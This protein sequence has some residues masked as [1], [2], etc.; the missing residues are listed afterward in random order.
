[1]CTI[2]QYVFLRKTI[3]RQTRRIR[4]SLGITNSEKD[5][6]GDRER[7]ENTS[8]R[9][10]V[11]VLLGLFLPSFLLLFFFLGSFEHRPG[12]HMESP[13]LAHALSPS[14]DPSVSSSEIFSPKRFTSYLVLHDKKP[15]TMKSWVTSLLTGE[16]ACNRKLYEGQEI[17]KKQK[18]IHYKEE[19]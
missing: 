17:I 8:R 3:I 19:I 15:F 14:W 1:M 2:A 10:D 5:K 7:E 13:L 11:P 16:I 6:L 9:R 4:E 18:R 12:V